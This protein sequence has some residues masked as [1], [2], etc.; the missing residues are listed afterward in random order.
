MSSGKRHTSTHQQTAGEIFD[1]VNELQTCC[2]SSISLS[3]F[4][5][6][7]APK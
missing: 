1:D 6:R 2:R 5:H 7:R 4:L 3:P